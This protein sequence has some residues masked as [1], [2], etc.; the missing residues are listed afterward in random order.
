MVNSGTYGDGIMLSAACHLFGRPII[1]VS[2]DE[3][4]EVYDSYAMSE[5]GAE[6]QSEKPAIILGHCAV[7]SKTRNHY[8]SLR[9]P[10]KRY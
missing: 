2:L 7:G 5:R 9:N 8:V 4:M 10:G 3:H 6:I 1:V